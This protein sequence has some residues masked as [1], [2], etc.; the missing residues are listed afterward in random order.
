MNDMTQELRT[1]QKMVGALMR[2]QG[3]LQWIDRVAFGQNEGGLYCSLFNS[4]AG[5]RICNVYSEQFYKLPDFVQALAPESAPEIS[6]ERA[7]VEKRG[8]LLEVP[9]FMITRYKLNPDDEQDKWRFGDVLY[10]ARNSDSEPQPRTTAE[11]GPVAP[12]AAPPVADNPFDGP[13]NL[14]KPPA[15]SGPADAIQWGVDT[16]VF[17]NYTAAKV[18]YENVKRIQM[19]GSTKEMFAAWVKRVQDLAQAQLA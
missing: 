14:D 4:K 19:P 16:G 17:I 13:V 5:F 11:P 6:T 10:V 7:R 3:L 12:V 18:A 15:F 8:L 2:H 9:G 1:L